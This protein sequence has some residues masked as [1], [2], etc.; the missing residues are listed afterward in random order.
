MSQ[1]RGPQASKSQSAGLAGLFSAFTVRDFRWVWAHQVINSLGMNMD[2]LAQGWL[3]LIMTDSPL[4]V[5]VASGLRGIG[6]IGFGAFGGVIADRTNRRNVLAVVNPVRGLVL[7]GLGLLVLTDQVELWHVLVVALLQGMADGVIAPAFNGLVYDTVGPRRLLNAMAA[8]QAAF[9][10][11]WMSGSIAIGTIISTVGIGAGYLAVAGAYCAGTAPL[12]FLR[13]Q[14]PQQRSHEPMWRTLAEGIKYAASSGPLRALLLLSVLMETFGFSYY[15]MLPVVARDILKVGASGLGYLSAAG[16]VGAMAGTFLLAALGDFKAKWP[17]LT[18][19]SAGAGAGLV[20]FALSPWFAVS[21]AVAGIVG[22]SLAVYDA[23]MA[24]LLQLLSA[25]AL[26]GR[27][28]GLYGMT[29]GFTPAGGF[30]AGM[31]ATIVSA[32]F[33][34]GLGGTI[35]VGYAT[36]VLTR[37]DRSKAAALSSTQPPHDAANE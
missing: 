34:I 23:S 15:V 2:L 18:V 24:T 21:L 19:A 3:V 35:I 20:V 27:I 16:S 31:V 4:W 8:L 17:M 30:I 9:H 36:G 26:R 13:P 14:P 6:H 10:L 25:D 29:W 12:L 22:S 37:T 7:A 1:E 33:A 11:A 28:L 32:P 5:G